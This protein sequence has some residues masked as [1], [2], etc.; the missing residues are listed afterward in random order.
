[1]STKDEIAPNECIV[2]GKKPP[3][4]PS[5]KG[6]PGWAFLSGAKPIGA[7]TCS[8]ECTKTAIERFNRTGRCD[9]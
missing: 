7:L 8:A 6:V 9:Q 3:P 1:M 4:S 2:C 5:G